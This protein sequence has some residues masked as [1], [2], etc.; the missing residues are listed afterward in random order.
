MKAK[1]MQLEPRKFFVDKNAK[2]PVTQEDT[3]CYLGGDTNK[4]GDVVTIPNLPDYNTVFVKLDGRVIRSKK[5]GET[6]FL[7]VI[8][9]DKPP[10]SRIRV[11]IRCSESLG[12][13]YDS[14]VYMCKNNPN[15]IEH[16]KEVQRRLNV[17]PELASLPEFEYENAKAQISQEFPRHYDENAWKYIATVLFVPTHN[18]YG[19]REDK[20]LGVWL[21]QGIP[22]NNPI[23][24]GI[25]VREQK[26]GI[27]PYVVQRIGE[28]DPK[29]G[30]D[31]I[32]EM[33]KAD[34]DF[35]FTHAPG[36]IRRMRKSDLDFIREML[37]VNSKFASAPYVVRRI[38]NVINLYKS[39]GEWR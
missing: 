31:A 33:L 7:Q 20:L 32:Q 25:R 23:C 22:Y 16:L 2:R 24:Y 4:W 10:R 1:D 11:F 5:C 9:F 37:K 27:D 13:N 38:R 3:W 15:F 26:I 17:E 14:T 36:V 29:L 18:I 6:W 19:Y 12:T 35:D 21:L 28:A 34:P 30:P 8:P 39:N